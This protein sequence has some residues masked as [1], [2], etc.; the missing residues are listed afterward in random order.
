MRNPISAQD[1][2]SQMAKGPDTQEGATIRGIMCWPIDQRQL[3]CYTVL[4]WWL[5]DCE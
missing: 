1:N 5:Q 4:A 2:P 3:D